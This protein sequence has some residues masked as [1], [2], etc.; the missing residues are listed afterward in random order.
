MKPS[1]LGLPPRF[2]SF[3][4]YPGFDQLACA[5]DLATAP[6]RF[7]I[8][9]AS[10]G[11]GK[12]ITYSSAAALRDPNARY[13]VLVGTKGLQT[14]L[15]DDGLVQRRVW[16]HRNYPCIPRGG[17]GLDDADTD[18]AD[19]RCMVP[20]DRC[21][22]AQDVEAAR[23]AKSVVA[24]NA[25]W[26]SIGRYGDPGLLGEF[27]YLILDECFP[28]D[29]LVGGRPISSIKV[30]DVVPSFSPY[31]E[32]IRPARVVATM[33]SRPSR[34][35]RLRL[36]NG[37]ELAGTPNHPILT[38]AGW[39]RMGALTTGSPVLCS[40]HGK[41][42]IP[43]R[44]H[45]PVQLV[46]S[47]DDHNRPAEV[48]RV[49][50]D[51]KGILLER[52][53]NLTSSRVLTSTSNRRA[54]QNA[55]DANE[56][57]KSNGG[58]SDACSHEDDTTCDGMEASHAGRER[59]TC[60]G[61]C[62]VVGLTAWLVRRVCSFARSG[63]SCRIAHKLQDRHCRACPE[64][65]YRGGRS[66]T[67]S[68]IK[69]RAGRKE[70]GDLVIAW[71]DNSEIL[72]PGSDGTFGGLCPDGLVYNL[73]VEGYHTYIANGVAVHNCHGV[74]G[75]LAGSLTIT[76]SSSRIRRILQR[77]WPKTLPTLTPDWHDWA[78]ETLAVALEVATRTGK[79]DPDRRRLER[80]GIDLRMLTKVTSPASFAAAGYTEPW[81]TTIA[82]NRES[83]QFTPRWGVDFAEKYLFRDIPY[84]L[85]T[86]ATVTL[87]HARYLGIPDAE[88]RYREVPS[89]FE[90]RRR[91]VVWIP[92]AR[93]SH[94][95]SDGAKFQV[96][97][98]VD[99]LI[100]A[101]IEQGA[102]NGIIHTGSYARNRELVAS[103]KFSAAIITHRQDSADFQAALAR[104]LDKCRRGEFAIFASPRIQEGV[105]LSDELGRWGIVLKMPYPYTLDPLT[106]ARASDSNYRD[107]YVAESMV[108][109]CGRL[110]R[111]ERDFGTIVIVDDHWEH[112]QRQSPFA[113]WFRAAFR[114]ERLTSGRDFK[115]LTADI[116]KGFQPARQITLI[117]A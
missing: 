65:G 112:Q 50:L 57:E 42:Q 64:G 10:T 9:N 26:L 3:R 39:V 98:R 72:E 71:V 19:F 116:V 11:S 80:L 76:M 110:V 96:A 45:S 106:R 32:A 12:S 37:Q 6:E 41:D 104:Y 51:W 61:T 113:L 85:L 18:D 70:D 95:M 54:A 93:L 102:G 88:M 69:K 56:N 23:N 33:N 30:G 91:P 108:Q 1:D 92:T 48:R 67:S 94:D 44:D 46:Q 14:Q 103:S 7:Q 77:S 38:P 107:L 60:N 117:G 35:V 115:F 27:D 40:R 58:F 114:T 4:A 82:E 73:E 34:L 49:P 55:L 43:P 99:E 68:D 79:T 81:I 52:V 74:P 15:L 90:P 2:T 25:Y 29:T 31:F 83:V 75:W 89:P 20:R 59:K 62:T 66:V 78:S 63:K 105:D 53:R 22:Y 47:S 28:P 84:V 87:Q 36:T 24:N 100:E 86:S 101:A 97:R 109:M 5:L 111:S 8:L 16:G 17:F 21:Q 13:L